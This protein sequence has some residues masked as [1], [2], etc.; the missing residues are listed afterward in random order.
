MP[1]GASPARI[2]G[3]TGR[4][5]AIHMRGAHFQVRLNPKECAGIT[6]SQRV[7]L[8]CEPLEFT[9]ACPLVYTT[10]EHPIQ[11]EKAT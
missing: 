9:L 10:L 6:A 11:H 8:R 4:T 5:R 3:D 2:Y 1:L 7:R